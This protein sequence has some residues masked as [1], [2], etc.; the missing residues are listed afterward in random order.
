MDATGDPGVDFVD[1]LRVFI[2]HRVCSADPY[3]TGIRIFDREDSFHP[4]PRGHQAL[5]NQL[6]TMIRIRSRI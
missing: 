6:S 4:N 5:A 1:V 2:G 3:A